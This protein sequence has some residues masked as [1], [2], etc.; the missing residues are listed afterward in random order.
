MHNQALKTCDFGAENQ[1]FWREVSLSAGAVGNS[2][3]AALKAVI[4]GGNGRRK[5]VVLKGSS[6]TAAAEAQRPQPRG[7]NTEPTQVLAV[8]CEMVGVGPDGARS[9][10]ARS[11]T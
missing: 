8:D 10:L 4:G 5:E 2:N 3:W 11:V 7:S 6:P 1:N 9:S